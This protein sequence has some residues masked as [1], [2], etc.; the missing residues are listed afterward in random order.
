MAI[1]TT[2]YSADAIFKLA[3]GAGN[4]TTRT[5]SFDIDSARATNPTTWE[6]LATS[7]KNW[8]TA[9]TVIYDPE[10]SPGLR[11]NQVIQPANW[12]DAF[13]EGAEDNLVWTT[14]DVNIV[15]SA[16]STTTYPSVE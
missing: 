1:T 15:I 12:E 2:R 13:G 6:S 4:T 7:M 16:K 9:D 3:D 5:I 14:V 10:A 11:Q 8:Y